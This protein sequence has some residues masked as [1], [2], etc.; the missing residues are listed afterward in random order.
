M[1][2]PISLCHGRGA[3]PDGN[4]NA[5]LRRGIVPEI[6]GKHLS[7]PVPIATTKNARIP[8]WLSNVIVGQWPSVQQTVSSRPETL[9]DALHSGRST[10]HR[11]P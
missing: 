10:D 3:L 4:R 8:M 5:A 7:E 11:A 2:G 6:V 9:T 1:P